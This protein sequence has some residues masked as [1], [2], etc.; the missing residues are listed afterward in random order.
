MAHR[1]WNSGLAAAPDASRNSAIIQRRLSETARNDNLL[2]AL[3]SGQHPDAPKGSR[4]RVL[5]LRPARDYNPAPSRKLS[6]AATKKSRPIRIKKPPV[7]FSKTQR[8]I[9]TIEQRLGCPLIA[10]WTS[11]AGSV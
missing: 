10:Y 3:R 9:S 6:M 11:P 7:L 2:G 8:L 5:S 4:A 1:G